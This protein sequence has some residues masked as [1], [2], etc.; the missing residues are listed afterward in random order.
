MKPLL[1]TLVLIVGISFAD[2]I[3]FDHLD[4]TVAELSLPTYN[5]VLTTS[6]SLVPGLGQ[7]ATRHGGK[8]TLFLGVNAL[9]WSQAIIKYQAIDAYTRSITYTD[10]LASLKTEIDS[11]EIDYWAIYHDTL[12]DSLVREDALDTVG[13]SLMGLESSYGLIEIN[14]MHKKASTQNWFIWAGSMYMWNLID[15]YGVSNHMRVSTKRTPRKA[16]F[17][18]AI[19]FT[20]A[21]QWYNGDPF[22]AG[23]VSASQIGFFVSAINFSLLRR[24]IERRGVGI[25]DYADMLM[26]DGSTRLVGSINRD[27]WQSQYKKVGDIRTQFLWYGFIFYMYGIVDA[28]VDA[29]LSDFNEKFD[30][31]GGYTPWDKKMAFTFSMKF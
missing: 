30:I 9:F 12:L 27:A 8:G 24:D 7:Y 10:T 19:P 18:S 17:L 2:S 13:S 28:Y 21:G 23:L 16:A 29:H 3:S 31:T 4:D 26:P 1:I 15:G 20:G 6:L 5:P 25:Y 11:V 14:Q 22:K